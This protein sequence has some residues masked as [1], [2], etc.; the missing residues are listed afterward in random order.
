MKITKLDVI[1]VEVELPEK[2]SGSAYS[3]ESRATLV[4][5]L[6]TDEG[7]V[8]VT[9]N[10]DE[11]HT[12]HEIARI[13][14]E[15]LFPLI[16]GG[17][18]L[19][20]EQMWHRMLPVTF[21]ILRDRKLVVMAMSAL[22]SALW[23]IVG[24]AAQMPLFQIWGAQRSELPIIAIGGYYKR[25]LT[26]LAE[27]VDYLRGLGLGGCKMKVG[28]AAP[29]EDAARFMAMADAAGDDFMLMADANQGYTLHQALQF[30]DNIDKRKL[31]WFEE[32]VRWYHDK[33][34]MRDV[35]MVGGVRVAAGQS[36]M[37]RQGVRELL[38]L[39]AVDVCNFDASW[40]GGPTE[41]RRV[42]GMCSA[43][44]VQMAH[45]EEGQISAHLLASSADA[46][47][48]E[49][50]APARDPLVWAIH[51]QGLRAKDGMYSVPTAPGLGLDLDWDWIKAHRVDAA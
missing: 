50:F 27:E 19:M 3:M 48:V 17:D 20:V 9:Y 41:W 23:D 8:G 35:R 44:G 25:S 18:P 46:G 36:E 34:W 12:Q 2:F 24:K 14:Q 21:D 11:V 32:P 22:D 13:M 4:T 26:Q 45:H 1:P 15:E 10:G 40:A 29:A 33:T 7:V 5:Q 16:Q 31:T 37:S 43:Y 39:G 49:V 42:E 47:P 38:E 30:L 51:A 6:H 28:G